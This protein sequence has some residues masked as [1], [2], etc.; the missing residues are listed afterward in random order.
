M[1]EIQT[2][3]FGSGSSEGRSYWNVVDVRF[4]LIVIQYVCSFGQGTLLLPTS[5]P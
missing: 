1:Y 5:E 2:A 4:F 3:I